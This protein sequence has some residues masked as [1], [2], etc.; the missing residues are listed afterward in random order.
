MNKYNVIA[1]DLA[2][3]VFQVCKTNCRGKIIY[4]KVVNRKQLK[5][6]LI[7]ENKSLVAMESCATSHYWARLAKSHGHIV[8]AMSARTVK[9]FLLGQKTDANYAVA[10]SIAALQP[11]VKSCRLISVEAQSLQSMERSR[12]LL[13]KQKKAVANQMRAQLLDFGFPI[14]LSDKKLREEIPIILGDA[15]NELTGDFRFSLNVMWEY[16]I[17][18]LA[19]LDEITKRCAKATN[20]NHFCK[21]LMQLEGV[22]PV[23]SLGLMISLGD[24]AHF[25]NGREASACMGATPVQH[26]SGGKTKLGSISKISGNKKLRA[27][28]YLGA[29]SVISKL[30]KREAKTEKEAWIKSMLLRRPYK[31]VAIAIVN[32]TIRT[33]YAMLKYDT[34]YKVT[35]LSMNAAQ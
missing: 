22:G 19:N 32:K 35:P 8:K 12:S 3:N 18:T 11:N 15:D 31:V 2:K 7:Q 29:T 23:G 28:L 24:T 13:S 1:I 9:G 6:L 21:R 4:N 20:E 14:E 5:A 10:I 33:A 16:F 17:K 25:K 30:Q 34:E 26:S 27:A